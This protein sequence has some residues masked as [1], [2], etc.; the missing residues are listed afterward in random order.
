MRL[1][2][3][4]VSIVWLLVAFLGSAADLHRLAAVGFSLSLSYDQ[5][6]YGTNQHGGSEKNACDIGCNLERRLIEGESN[7]Q[8]DGIL[9]QEERRENQSDNEEGWLGPGVG[10]ADE[11]KPE[12]EEKQKD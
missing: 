1:P 10:M 11:A 4:D 6:L 3:T 5:Q 12:E 8:V 2:S 9:R 7:G